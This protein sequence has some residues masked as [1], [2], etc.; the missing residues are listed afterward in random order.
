MEQSRLDEIVD[1]LIEIL[2]GEQNA[3]VGKLGLETFSYA[4]KR[5]IVRVL[6]I[7]REPAPLTQEFMKLQNE[8]LSYET[9]QRGIAEIDGLK[10]IHG[11]AIYRGDIRTLKVDA[12]VNAGNPAMLGSFDPTDNSTDAVIMLAGGLQIRQELSLLKNRTGRDEERG[13][14][15]VT[16]AY[17]LP[18]KY[19]IHTVGPEIKKGKD[20]SYRDKIDLANCYKACLNLAE[21]KGLVSIAFCAIS[22]GVYNFPK[23]LASKIAVSTVKDW[24]E[25]TKSNIKVVFCVFDTDTKKYYEQNFKN[26][27]IR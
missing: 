5:E 14:A 1:R 13:T 21:E 19:V 4:E 2:C 18:C 24:L 10:F 27:D 7:R 20:V 9:E 15:V 3:D 6:S 16:K 23:E 17:N 25:D 8:L 11:M 26:Y 12:I 22:T